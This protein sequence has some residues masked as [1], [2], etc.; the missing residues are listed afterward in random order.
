MTAPAMTDE[1]AAGRINYRKAPFPWFGG[2]SRAAP[3]VWAA[4]GDV[5]HYVEPFAGSLAVLLN[6]PHPC[7]RAYFSETVNDADGLLVNVWRAIQR[8]PEATAAH[9]SWPVTECDKHARQVALLRW[10][11]AHELEHLMGDP[12]WCD[13]QMAGWWLYGICLQIGGG[14]CAGEG[15]W[16][17]DATG[18]LVKQGKAPRELGISR[19]LPRISSNGC[20]VHRPQLREPGVSCGLPNISNDGRGVHRPQLREPGV[21]CGLPR[22]SD[23]GQGV[24]RPQ[25]R[26]PGVS[27]ERPH[28]SNNGRGVHHARL[29]EPGV[30]SDDPDNAFHP[31]TMPE[32]VRWFQWLSARLRHVRIIN[33]DWARVCTTGALKTLMVRQGKGVAGIFLDPP[34]SAGTGRDMGLYCVESGDVA[35]AVRE[36]CLKNG[37]DPAYR[38]VLAGFEGE[39]EELGA[40]GWRSVEWFTP[41]FLC[42]G[43]ANQGQS[44]HQQHRERL[45]LSP[46]CLAPAVPE[47]AQ[48]DTDELVTESLA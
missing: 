19:K 46:H 30:L 34:Y 38:I 11:E 1:L 41:G 13:P 4:L 3:V 23:D 29:R 37:D 16:T 32:L 45:W 8:Q 17:A 26:E 12:G 27:R 21:S 48:E 25:L 35:H 22:I 2:K 43:M 44:G 9:A 28:V 7:N 18:R 36:W 39:H 42:G 5:A 24:H 15:P 40:M 6:R 14:W 33:G 20:G 31:L 47:A 10:R